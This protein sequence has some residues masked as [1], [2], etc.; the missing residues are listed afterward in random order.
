MSDTRSHHVSIIKQHLNI[1]VTNH[2]FWLAWCI[3][4]SGWEPCN[5]ISG[6]HWNP[7]NTEWR[8]AGSTRY[9]PAGVQNFPTQAE[10]I[11]A[12]VSTLSLSY[13]AELIRAC[14]EG[15]SIG[16]LANLLA[17]SPYGTGQAIWGG[18][19]AYQNDPHRAAT[20]PVG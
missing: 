19:S 14:R 12:I 7:L 17:H 5:G 15:R 10:G 6:A 8:E 4:E 1:R 9:N 16:Y 20:T 13:Y 18:V 11:S 2:G 3:A